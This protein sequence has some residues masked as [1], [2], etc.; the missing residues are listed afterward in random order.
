[1]TLIDHK[2]CPLGLDEGSDVDF[3]SLKKSTL[4]KI[5]SFLSLTAATNISLLLPVYFKDVHDV[6]QRFKTCHDVNR[7]S[8]AV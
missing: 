4:R 8:L 6:P 2:T 7:P 5:P 3:F 1:M